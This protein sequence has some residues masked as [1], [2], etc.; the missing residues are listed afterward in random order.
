MGDYLHGNAYHEAGHAVVGSSLGLCVLE[1]EI[2]EDRPGD[3]TEMVGEQRLSL[4]ER[5][6]VHVAGYVAEDLFKHPLPGWASGADHLEVA[7]LLIDLPKTQADA[8]RDDGHEC[9]R[10]L[11][12]KHERNVHKV[13]ARLIECRHMDTSEFNSLMEIP[14]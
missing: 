4:T 6:A 7:A 1:I 8:L 3:N 14:D 10:K 13:A 11:L 12:R 5:I 9:A 2:R